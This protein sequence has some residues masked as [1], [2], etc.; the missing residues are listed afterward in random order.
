[1]I[2]IGLLNQVSGRP[3]LEDICNEILKHLAPLDADATQETA[4]LQYSTMDIN[5]RVKVLQII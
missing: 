4:R 3:R 5:L 2:I 1:M